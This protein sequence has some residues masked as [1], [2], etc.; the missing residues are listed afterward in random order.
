MNAPVSGDTP[1]GAGDPAP[2]SRSYA[3]LRYPAAR[4]YLL[5]AALAMMADH[6]EHAISYWIIFTKFDSPALAGFA[7]I[8]HWV[9]FLLGSIWAG[10]LADRFDPRRIIQIG[11]ALF[12]AVSL[13][14]GLLFATDSLQQWHAGILLIAHGCAGA[15]WA[16]ASQVLI[17]QIVG[18]RQLQSGIRLMATSLTL[19]M[20]MGPAVG[21][22]LLINLGPA[23]GIVV[24][25]AIYLPLLLWL[26]RNPAWSR[27]AEARPASGRM[28]SYRDLFAT[29]RQISGVP[30]VLAM[31]LL[32]GLS[33]ALVGVGYHP[34]LPEFARDFG[35]GF[36]GFRY[37]LLLTAYAAGAVLAGLVLEARQLLATQ[38]R[39]AVILAILWCAAIGSFAVVADYTVAIALLLCAGFFEL[40]FVSMARTL[41]QLAAPAHMRGR[42]I[43]LFNVGALGFRTFSGI[44]IG[45]GGGIIGIHWSLGLSAAALFVVL[46][47]LLA[48]TWRVT[49][50]ATA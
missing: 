13:G 50:P 33:A 6:V 31:T 34:N 46:L 27:S 35:F 49:Y 26:V 7:V 36:D 20:L 25:A 17:H 16:P 47:A 30:V 12:M 10:A 38:P 28:T 18:T 5:F 29:L 3:A 9:P 40:A 41:A 42:A 48:W 11:M 32:A 2:D 21:G 8:S 22:A 44:T 19:G 14:W 37:T 15:L 24:N 1:G 23:A 43:G 39:T 45:F 4:T